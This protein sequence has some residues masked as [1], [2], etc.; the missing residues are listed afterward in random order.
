MLMK[1]IFFYLVICEKKIRHKEAL[2]HL[3][4]FFPIPPVGSQTKCN[5]LLP[6][7]SLSA[8]NHRYLHIHSKRQ[9]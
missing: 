7:R 8:G 1:Q 4:I 3:K 2:Q 9:S 6:D 5:F